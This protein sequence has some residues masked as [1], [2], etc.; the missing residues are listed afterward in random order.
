[1]ISVV[2]SEM[3]IKITMRYKYRPIRIAKAEKRLTT[4]SFGKT[5]EELE[6][7]YSWWEC[8]MLPP[9]RR[10]LW[11]FLKKLKHTPVLGIYPRKRKAYVALTNVA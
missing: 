8:K 2:I 5:V 4:L 6:F 1:M 11:Q 7:L 3:Q 9:L 10:T